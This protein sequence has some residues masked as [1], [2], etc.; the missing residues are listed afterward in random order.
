MWVELSVVDSI[1]RIEAQPT[2]RGSV[3]RIRLEDL[4]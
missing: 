3:V 2:V 1:S 4:S